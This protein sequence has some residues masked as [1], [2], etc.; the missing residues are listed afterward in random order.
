MQ[1]MDSYQAYECFLYISHYTNALQPAYQYTPNLNAYSQ[2]HRNLVFT[3]LRSLTSWNQINSVLSTP[4]PL[5]R[6][7]MTSQNQFYQHKAHNIYFIQHTL[8]AALK[9][10][11]DTRRILTGIF[12]SRQPD[13]CWRGSQRHSWGHCQA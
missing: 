1:S 6:F 8:T 5:T 10:S 11:L 12:T 3:N 7:Y 2:Y 9:N 4:R 13:G